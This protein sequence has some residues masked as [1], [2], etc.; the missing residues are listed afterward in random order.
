MT[1]PQEEQYLGAM[2]VI[3][4]S[5]FAR[6][7]S[8][9]RTG[10]FAGMWIPEEAPWDDGNSGAKLAGSYE[11]ELHSALAL[12]VAR[13]VRA[14]VNVGCAEGYYAVGLAMIAPEVDVVACDLD[15]RSLALCLEGALRNGV[16]GRVSARLGCTT[17]VA[18]A[19]VPAAPGH[20]LYLLDCEGAELALLDP[21]RCPALV[22]SDVIVECHDFM[23]S[24]ISK[25]LGQRFMPTHAVFKINPDLQVPKMYPFLRGLPFGTQLLA[26]AEK[27][28]MPSCWLACW[29]NS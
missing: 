8:R 4:A 2:R 3:N 14:I 15:R 29:A 11:F 24:A 26:I 5:L 13:G 21:V 27:R 19:A 18:L 25:V 23:Y 12:A 10:P 1:R 20:R 28:P 7:G 22:R 9:V 6:L 17:P 16:A